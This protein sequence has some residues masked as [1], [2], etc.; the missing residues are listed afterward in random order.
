MIRKLTLTAIAALAAALMI[1]A[2]AAA[3]GPPIHPGVQTFTRGAQCTSNFVFKRGRSTFIGQAAHCS[4]T[5]AADETDGC[6]ARSLPLGTKVVVDGARDPGTLAYNSW[7]TM[8]RVGERGEETCAY[9]DLALVKLSRFDARRVDPSIPRYGG[10]RGIGDAASGQRVYTYGSSSLRAGSNALSPKTGRVISRSPGGWSYDVYTAT[11]GIPGDSG[12]A[13][14]NERGQAL[15]VLSTVALAPLAGSNGVGSIA[16]ELAY[17]RS[18]GLPR[19]R[20]LDGTAPFR[21]PPLG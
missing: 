16:K 9:N 21:P 6:K 3:G 10:P 18:H 12:S 20:L 5:G 15:G 8:Q 11:P 17:A 13:F 2:A 14:L 19:L 4:G 1:P 7:L